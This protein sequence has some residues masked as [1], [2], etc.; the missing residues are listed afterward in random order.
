MLTL[1]MIDLS[2]KFCNMV[3]YY[4]QAGIEYGNCFFRRWEEE[5]KRIDLMMQIGLYE[6]SLTLQLAPRGH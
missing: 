5:G 1:D 2:A 4:G 3:S 6:C